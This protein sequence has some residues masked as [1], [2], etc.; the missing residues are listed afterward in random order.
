MGI[1]GRF[2]SEE[3]IHLAATPGPR[4]RGAQGC[5]MLAA[6]CAIVLMLCL[7][8]AIVLQWRGVELPELS[9]QVGAYRIV[10]IDTVAPGCSPV[11]PCTQQFANVPLPRYYVFWLI[12]QNIPNDTGTRVLTI[13]LT[14]P[15][16][17]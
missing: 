17:Q 4:R 12:S 8:G 7:L 13:P 11:M 1:A 15:I 2:D 5:A 16:A 9:G 14:L 3:K 6:A 10:V